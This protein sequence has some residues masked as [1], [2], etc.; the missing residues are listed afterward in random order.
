MAARRNRKSGRFS[1]TTRRRKSKSFNVMKAAE[2]A[3]VANA[4][5]RGLFNV[6]LPTFVTGK[7][8]AGGFAG[9]NNSY[10]ITIPELF[11]L[12]MGG[13]G[14]IVPSFTHEGEKGITAVLKR[15]VQ[16]N[17]VEAVIS[18]VA[19]P[20]AFRLGRKILS[21]PLINPTNRML[22]SVG[23]KEVKL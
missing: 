2:T 1:K 15:N 22:R 9:D 18:M 4:A 5:V 21:K 6:N 23:V 20:V 19:I 11:N 10:D 3:L 13:R 7:D 16:K 14:G 8:I 12:A 17:G